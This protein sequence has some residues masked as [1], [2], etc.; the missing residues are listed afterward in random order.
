MGFEELQSRY[1]EFIEERDWDRFHQPKNIAMA[2]SV[3][4]SELMELFQWKDNVSIQKISYDEEHDILYYNEGESV[5]D[6]LELGDAFIE[7]SN[8]GK[9]VGVE[10]M[11]AS[12]FLSIQTGEEITREMLSEAESGDISLRHNKDMIFIIFEFV[13]P[14]ESEKKSERISLNIPSQAATA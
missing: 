7:L 1:Q 9:I 12:D 14:V 10:I 8:D 2:L 6:S 11:N 5:S 3:E 4:V 13:V